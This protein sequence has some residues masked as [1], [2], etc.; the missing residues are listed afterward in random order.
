MAST[1][2]SRSGT[3]PTDLGGYLDI[4]FDFI[5]Y[6]G[7]A[8]AFA[9]AQ[10]EHAV[11]AAFLI[12]SFMGT[13]SSF[14]AFAIFAAKRK[15]DGEAAAN[16]SFYYLGGITEGTE[17][18]LL[19]VVVLLFP[20]W[21]PGR[22][23]PLWG[24]VLADHGRAHRGGGAEIAIGGEHADGTGGTGVERRD[25]R[26]L[27]RLWAVLQS[28][29]R[30]AVRGHR[31]SR[32]SRRGGRSG[33]AV[34]RAVLRRGRPR[35]LSA[36][37]VSGVTLPRL[38]WVASHAGRGHAAVRAVSRSAGDAAIRSRQRRLGGRCGNSRASSSAPWRCITS[39]APASAS[40][41]AI[42]TRCSRRAA[43][44]SWRTSCARHRRPDFRW[45]RRRMSARSPSGR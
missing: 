22:G 7:A 30:T 5:I 11:A 18:I 36:G 43:P 21:F 27:H 45:R 31:R 4:V 28:G 8:F 9:L 19:F 16:K 39:M 13:G 40:C 25:L 14:L 20:G 29:A 1:A 24:A 41:S 26:Q 37:P 10:P 42:S 12:F 32:G 23:L 6:A 17:T 35:G 3:G 38:R 34:S 2:R 33:A 44:S 15:L